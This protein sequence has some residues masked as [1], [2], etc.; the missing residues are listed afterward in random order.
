M[1]GTVPGA[2]L[3]LTHLSPQEVRSH[4]QMGNT[5]RLGDWPQS[6]H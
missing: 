1:L 3:G 2:L 5:E 6:A 4:S